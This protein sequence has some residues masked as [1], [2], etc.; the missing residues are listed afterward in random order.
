MKNKITTHINIKEARKDKNSKAPI[1]IRI[2]VNGERA[3]MQIG[4]FVNSALW[5]QD[6]KAPSNNS[7]SKKLL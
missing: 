7:D 2:T 1:Y 6:I 5:D 3:E 4:K